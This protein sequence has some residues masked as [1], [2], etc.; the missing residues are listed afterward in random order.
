MRESSYM[1]IE[2]GKRINAASS[3]ESTIDI[4]KT[5][6]GEGYAGVAL[7]FVEALITGKKKEVILSVPNM[8]AI[9][10]LEDDD[11][12]EITC[13]ADSKGAHPVKIG[14]IPELQMSL[15]RQVKLYERL[16]VDAIKSKSISLAV[17]ALMIHP[18][19]C[20]YSISKKLVNRFLAEYE[21]YTGIW[22]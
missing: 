19:V 16:T 3:Q 4:F 15:I 22:R 7:D 2:S 9:E 18:L 13:I 8:G 20:S 5:E 12:V 17:N 21:N 14:Q 11:V 6:F 1:S 10:G